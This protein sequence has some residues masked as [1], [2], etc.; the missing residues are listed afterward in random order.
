[1]RGFLREPEAV[2]SHI[3]WDEKYSV[4][5]EVID[6]QHKHLFKVLGDLFDGIGKGKSREILGV[7]LGE[8]IR[9]ALDHFRTE[10][11]FMRQYDFPGYEQHK[12]EHEAFKRK[13]AVF[14]KDFEAGKAT[15]TL[16]VISFLTGWLDHHIL[17][18]DREYGPFLNEKGIC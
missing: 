1:M 8:L 5:I 14:Q 7:T 12:K 18:V 17:E 10:E 11:A 4:H 3:V 16:E 9:Y 6:E 2:V 15:L 13:V